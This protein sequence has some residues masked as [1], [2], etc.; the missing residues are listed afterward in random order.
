MDIDSLIQHFGHSNKFVMGHIK[1]D[2]NRFIV[3]IKLVKE[4]FL[5][6]RIVKSKLSLICV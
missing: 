5:G 4:V 3:V 1:T 2:F 6:I